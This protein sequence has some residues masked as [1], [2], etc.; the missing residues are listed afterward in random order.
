MQKIL[1]SG[2][3]GF[4]F[5][6]FIRQAIYEKQSYNF[7]SLDRVS[8]SKVLNS[9]Y[10]NK[11]HDFYFGDISDSHFLNILFEF[12]RPNIVIHG[13]AEIDIK[14][15]FIVSNV[16]GTQ[17]IIDCCLK[18]GTE[19]LIFISDDKVYGHLE[20]ETDIPF[21]ETSPLNPR[22]AYAASKAAGE[23]LV[24]AAHIS[25]ELSFNIIRLSNVYGPRQSINSL[26]PKV[27]KCIS[28]GEKIPVYGQGHQIRDW[29]HVYDACSAILTVLNAGKANEIY[30]A[31]AGQELA[32]IEVIQR[33]CN[34]MK[35]GH[36]LISFMP[37][38]SGADFR[39]ASNNSKLKTLNWK[40]KFKF[41]DGVIDTKNW[42]HNNQWSLK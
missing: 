10:I 29:M 30:N 26:I 20:K 35:K 27:I 18:W 9:L 19:R 24:Q 23:L 2:S 15:P 12:E 8:E 37:E 28:S 16:L 3:G 38:T 34:A 41:S 31:S 32:T 33:V 17:N 39:R 11:D 13:A 6:N 22:N 21:L 36:D 14:K 40:P 25:H 4:L 42:F 1:I 7:I 5:S